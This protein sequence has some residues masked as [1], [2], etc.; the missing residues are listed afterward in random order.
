MDDHNSF[1]ASS[2]Q[3][4]PTNKRSDSIVQSIDAH[5]CTRSQASDSRLQQRSHVVILGEQ[6]SISSPSSSS[7]VACISKCAASQITRLLSIEQPHIAFHVLSTEG[8]SMNEANSHVIAEALIEQCSSATTTTSCLGVP[9]L[10]VAHELV[11]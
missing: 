11:K 7:S 6:P 1:V 8:V 10:I 3:G 5:T 9:N 2:I 4:L